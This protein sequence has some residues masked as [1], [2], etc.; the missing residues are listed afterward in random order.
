MRIM[1]ENAGG[2]RGC[3]IV[4]RDGCLSVEGF[5]E[6]GCAV[7]SAARSI[8]LD[9]ADG[10][11]ALP[12]SIIYHVLHTNTPVVLH[13]T[14]RPGPFAKDAYLLA[15]RPQSV[16][17]IPIVR[18]GKFEGAIYMENSLAAGVF[19]DDRIEM[20]K[21]LAAQ[22]SI[23]IENAKLYQDQ[24]HLIE[25]QRR[26]VPRQFLETL[27]RHDIAH[28]DLG[29][30]VAKTMSV[31]FADLRDFTPLAESLEPRTVIEL[32]NRF[33]AS[34][35]LPILQAG[36]FVDLF[37]GDEIKVLFDASASPADAIR[38]G[39]AMW[40]SLDE[41]NERSI[42]LGQPELRMGIGVSTGS[43]VLGTVGGPNRIQCSVVGDTVN[44]ASRIEQLTK[45]YRARFL[46]GAHTVHSLAESREF[47]IRKVDRVAVK[48]KNAPFDIYEVIDAETPQRA[49]AKLATR[50][51]LHSAMKRYFGREFKAALALFEQACAEDPEDVVPT[52]FTERCARYLKAPPPADWQGFEKLINK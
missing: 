46:I 12:I 14:A 2:Q 16:L 19:T 51:I 26:F 17:C 49:G 36:G 44:L 3:F 47:A 42:T 40:R 34:M 38:A 5:S 13:D 43:V 29:E 37:A 8:H 35:E 6:V 33:F 48:G 23:S 41:L 20:I 50:L 18:Q 24:L 45:I 9:G 1:L 7:S 21:L 52:I 30:N 39:I 11:L 27:G 10:S 22:V 4:C 25:A 32:L 28:V 31:M 15:R